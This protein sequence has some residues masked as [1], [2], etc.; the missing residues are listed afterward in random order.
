MKLYPL[1]SIVLI[2]VICSCNEKESPAMMVDETR[3]TYY[4]DDMVKDYSLL[5]LKD[6]SVNGLVGK[7][8]KVLIDD[9]LIFL[10]HLPNEQSGDLQQQLGVYDLNG[11]YLH[12]IG[13]TGRAFNE[14][15]A[16]RDWNIDIINK[17]VL[18]YDPFRNRIQKYSYDG[19]FKGSI[20]LNDEILRANQVYCNNSHI[21]IQSMIPNESSDDITK[22]LNDG[23]KVPLMSKRKLSTED[24]YISGVN[25]LSNPGNDTLYHIRPLDNIL[26][27][28]VGQE[29]HKM[30]S[31]DFILIPSAKKMKKFT[32]DDY[33]YLIAMPPYCYDTK[34]YYF[35]QT[36]QDGL[37]VFSKKDIKWT[38]YIEEDQINATILIPNSIVGVSDDKL[39]GQITTTRAR[40]ELKYNQ[41]L[42]ENEKT[43]FN[44]ILKSE[45]STLVLYNLK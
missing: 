13:H 31:L 25:Q 44:Q 15:Q 27:K 9:D 3:N 30:Q 40:D 33:E 17:E 4:L 7:I 36:I 2:G 32:T 21:Y 28:I 8:K 37:Y 16:V 11:N 10:S 29:C 22:I 14:Y 34:S 35:V 26:Y 23:T 1:F 24:F 12:G 18:V 5:T 20:T 19:S 43:L 42:T 45:N 41:D 38:H 6:D 39:I